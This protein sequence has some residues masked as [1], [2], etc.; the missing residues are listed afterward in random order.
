MELITA[1][2]VLIVTLAGLD[3][4]ALAFGVDSRESLADDRAR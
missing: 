3:V 4:A 2:L 1:L